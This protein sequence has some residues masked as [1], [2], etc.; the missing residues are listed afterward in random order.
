VLFDVAYDPWPS[1]LARSWDAAGGTV[2]S[3]LELLIHQAVGQIRLFVAGD[4]RLPLP[5]EDAVVA[6]MRSAVAAST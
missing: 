4:Q 5:R 1:A 3:G 6:A 2:I